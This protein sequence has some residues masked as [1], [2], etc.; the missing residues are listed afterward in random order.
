MCREKHHGEDFKKKR[1]FR[2]PPQRLGGQ[3]GKFQQRMRTGT[4]A[5]DPRG[6][7]GL[8][9]E[10]KQTKARV[11]RH[12]AV[13]YRQAEA[14]EA[15][16]KYF[17][18]PPTSTLVSARRDGKPAVAVTSPKCVL[19]NRRRGPVPGAPSAVGRRGGRRGACRVCGAT[20]GGRCLGANGAAA[21]L[22]RRK[23]W[24]A[25]SAV[26]RKY[27]FEDFKNGGPIT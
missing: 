1:T 11:L 10:P 26:E 21:Y 18:L 8:R 12:P 22:R 24:K 20:G 5:A 15:R 3:R 23:G 4:M 17:R 16:R 2:Q 7:W 14:P 13:G 6:L 9:R 25:E 27:F 19:P